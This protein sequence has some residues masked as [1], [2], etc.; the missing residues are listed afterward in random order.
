MLRICRN[1]TVKRDGCEDTCIAYKIMTAPIE[2]RRREEMRR[3]RDM[4]AYL[5]CAHKRIWRKN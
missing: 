2:K 3:Q 5:R 4:D 1:C